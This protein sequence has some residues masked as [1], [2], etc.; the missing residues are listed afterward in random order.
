MSGYSLLTGIAVST[1]LIACHFV[2]NEPEG[3][4]GPTAGAGGA[5]ITPSSGG[6]TNHPPTAGAA[7]VHPDYD[8]EAGSG[9]VGGDAEA[10][11]G[12]QLPAS[13]GSATGGT[14]GGSVELAGDGG[15]APAECDVPQATC[16][17]ISEYDCEFSQLA[18]ATAVLACGQ[19]LPVGEANCGQCG[20]VAVKLYFDGRDCWQGIPDCTTTNFS[21]K[22]LYPHSP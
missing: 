18:G 1:C 5:E 7:N 16:A 15:A 20:L 21:K 12:G 14:G 2:P 17:V 3:M 8:A 13:A 11:S 19:T 22:F 9:G 10:G 4:S 6:K